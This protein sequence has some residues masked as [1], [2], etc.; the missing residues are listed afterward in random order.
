MDLV[1]TVTTNLYL[2]PFSSLR[3]DGV[4]EKLELGIMLV[5]KLYISH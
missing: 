2:T 4:D 5:L 1:D 3:K